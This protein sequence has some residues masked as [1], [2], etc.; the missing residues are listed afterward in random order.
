MNAEHEELVG[1]LREIESRLDTI[2]KQLKFQR[3]PGDK[4]SPESV[5]DILLRIATAVCKR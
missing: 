3:E 1:L 5:R 2:E 4:E